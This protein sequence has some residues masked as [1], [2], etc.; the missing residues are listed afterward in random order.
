MNSSASPGSEFITG[1]EGWIVNSKC[2]EARAVTVILII[3]NIITVPITSLLNGLVIIAVKR[4]PQLKTI[5]VS[6]IALACLATTDCFM[7]VI[8]QPTFIALNIVILQVDGSNTYCFIRKLSNAVI[9]VLGRA[10]LLHLTLIFLDRYIAIKHP[11]RYTNV[12]TQT[13]ILC[14]STFV[15]IVALLSTAT[16][17]T[18]NNSLGQLYNGSTIIAVCCAGIIIFCQVVL[19]YEARRQERQIAAHHV[20]EDNRQKLVKEKKAL[21]LTTTVLFFLVL[22]YS[23]LIVVNILI[24]ISFIESSCAAHIALAIACFL[25]ILNS[26]INPTIYCIRR[27]QFRVA[28]IEI[29]LR[30]SNVEA[31][32]TEMQMNRARELG[33]RWR[34]QNNEQKNSLSTTNNTVK[35]GVSNIGCHKDQYSNFNS[36]NIISGNNT[37]NSKNSIGGLS[38]NNGSGS[39]HSNSNHIGITIDDNDSD[40]NVYNNENDSSGTNIG[41]KTK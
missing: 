17:F 1:C 14:S 40:N 22:S 36:D 26:L 32:E 18:S 20:S 24:R 11:Y 41:K 5:H 25:I 13:R 15:W 27:R 29:L 12:V 31:Q 9:T 8:G 28:F 39:R 21:K 3:V 23:P 38:G 37:D 19:Y 6:N 33:L 16:S 2:T 10:S 4:K 35:C 30:K 7:G 34:S